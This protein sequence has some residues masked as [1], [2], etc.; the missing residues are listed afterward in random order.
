MRG[1]ILFCGCSPVAKVPRISE[2]RVLIDWSV[3]TAA[4]RC[5]TTDRSPIV[6]SAMGLSMN[7]ETVWSSTV[8]LTIAVPGFVEVKVVLAIP[9]LV[10]AETGESIRT[11]VMAEYKTG[12]PSGT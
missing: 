9:S 8:A 7:V 4:W 10:P 1:W 3:N 6:K 11:R 5:R 2:G 12:I